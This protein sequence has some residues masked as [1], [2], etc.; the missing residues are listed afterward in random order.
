MSTNT[1]TPV[2]VHIQ[3][4]AGEVLRIVATLLM[5]GGLGMLVWT[6]AQGPMAGYAATAAAAT[7]VF[8][9]GQ[10]WKRGVIGTPATAGPAGQGGEVRSV[11]AS[12]EAVGGGYLRRCSMPMLLL[13]A[14][15]YGIV[16][17][18][19]R[20]GL[21]AVLSVVIGDG[22]AAGY[23]SI[24]FTA[25]IFFFAGQLWERSVSGVPSGEPSADAKSSGDEHVDYLRSVATKNTAMVRT[26][27]L[28]CNLGILAAI[29]L[30]YGVGFLA[31]REAVVV[32]LG[33]FK[34]LYVAGGV[35]LLV[36]SL[37]VMPTLIPNMIGGLRRAGVIRPD[38]A[39]PQAITPAAQTAPDPAPAPQVITPAPQVPI[40][41]APKPVKHVVRRVKKKE[42]TDV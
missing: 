4:G 20:E 12:I 31:V 23:T 14:I 13:I 25:A 11:A 18:A 21:A 9:A 32:A 22:A 1:N 16:F 28:T 42:N 10:L 34:N 39:A 17:L 19:V 35:A 5:F 26:F 36:G 2:N 40:A 6:I 38:A 7:V 29:A 8:F 37:V 3:T 33:V 27:L 15:G 41:P 30:G 24:G